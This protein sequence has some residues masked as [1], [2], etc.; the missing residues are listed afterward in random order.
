[1]L[2]IWNYKIIR[3]YN[4]GIVESCQSWRFERQPL[5]TRADKGIKLKRQ[6]RNSSQISLFFPWSNFHRHS[7]TVV[8][9]RLK[10]SFDNCVI[11]LCLSIRVRWKTPKMKQEI[12][13]ANWM[14]KKWNVFAVFIFCVCFYIVFTH[15]FGRLQIQSQHLKDTRHNGV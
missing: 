12:N 14:I 13:E 5:V 1:M 4:V 2:L 3:F 10:P 11:S 7:T 8:L 15:F 6:L 9:E